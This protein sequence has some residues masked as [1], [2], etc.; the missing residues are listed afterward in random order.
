MTCPP[1]PPKKKEKE[2]KK[3]RE[4]KRGGEGRGGEG[5]RGEGRGREERRGA[6][7]SLTQGIR[8]CPLEQPVP[9]E[10]LS[11]PCVFTSAPSQPL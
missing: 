4:E 1:T 3:R 11:V 9:L 8:I 6:M 2:K 7:K 5:R 10:A